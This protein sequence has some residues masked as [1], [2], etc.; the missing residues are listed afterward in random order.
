MV[1]FSLNL[2]YG[3]VVPADK[4]KDIEKKLTNEQYD[5][6]MDNYA[7]CVNSWTGEDY[8]IGL[9]SFVSEDGIDFVYTITPHFLNPFTEKE[10]SDFKK[11]F[12]THNL[13]HFIDWKPT[14]MLIN[15]C[16]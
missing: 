11:F 16:S 7:R 8:F 2:C 10:L 12:D 4:M 6:L 14:L 13:W 3:I 1:D 15:F 5:E 9:S